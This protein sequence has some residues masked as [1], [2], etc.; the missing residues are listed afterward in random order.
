LV[1]G[2]FNSAK[3]SKE[4]KEAR[5][6]LRIA[7]EK[8]EKEIIAAKQKARV[9]MRKQLM[10]YFPNGGTPLTAHKIT[11]PE[12]Y[13]FG[14]VVD[15]AV[16]NNETANVTVSNVFPVAQYSDGS[17]PLKTSVSNKLKGIAKGNVVLVGFYSDKN[18]ADQMRNSFIALA[19]KSELTVNPF[20]FKTL[21]GNSAG[22]VRA[23]G[24]F[25]ETD[26]KIK[27]VAD[28]TKK[29]NDFWNN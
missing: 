24:D 28:T 29:K 14:Y 2:I 3:A 17:Y 16:I 8:Q 22:S 9:E 11:T 21:G 23:T 20:T 15:P 27:A 6:A 4:A 13:M 5:E 25:W 19:Q 10:K 1:G 7:K 12:V 26:A 18:A